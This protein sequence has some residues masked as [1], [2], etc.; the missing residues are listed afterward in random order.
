MKRGG[1][2]GGGNPH[3]HNI[4]IMIFYKYLPA[5]QVWPTKQMENIFVF[6][7]SHRDKRVGFT[8]K[9]MLFLGRFWLGLIFQFPRFSGFDPLDKR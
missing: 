3:F 9:L 5:T 7:L 8:S 1:C 2:I 4:I 6:L